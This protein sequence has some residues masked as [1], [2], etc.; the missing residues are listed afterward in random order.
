MDGLGDDVITEVEV[1][2][3]TAAR[4]LA[5]L[6]ELLDARERT[7]SL[8]EGQWAVLTAH[9]VDASLSNDDLTLE[10]A[11][12]GLQWMSAQ[13]ELDHRGSIEA[14]H[15]RGRVR[16]VL[17]VLRWHLRRSVSA[18]APAI[19]RDGLA[20]RMLQLIAQDPG[21]RNQKI[22][23]GLGVDQTQV[24]RVGRHLRES[25]LASIRKAGRENAWYVTPKGVACLQAIGVDSELRV[26][27][28]GESEWARAV[29]PLSPFA[30]IPLV[31]PGAPFDQEVSQ[32]R[33][34]RVPAYAASLGSAR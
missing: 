17:D 26:E 18:A 34:R 27:P 31:Q 23:L 21:S 11:Y 25:S 2:A 4:R 8:D 1:E 30:A 7:S 22:A 16:G 6:E 33:D 24:S 20:A 29:E 19:P 32:P 10:A 28:V 13:L 14:A 15:E 9:V 3:G 12:A 5:A